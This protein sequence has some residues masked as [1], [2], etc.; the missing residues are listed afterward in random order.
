MIAKFKPT[1]MISEIYNISPTKLDD[2][3]I[4]AVFS[5]LDNT[6]IPWNNPDGTPQLRNWI[7]DL[8]KN[9][10]KLVVISNNKHSRVKRALKSLKLDFISRSCKPMSRG[11]KAALKKY[12]LDRNQVIMVGDQLITDVWASN[13]SKVRSVLVKP[14]IES[15]AWNTKPNRMMETVLWKL[16]KRKYNDLNWQEDIDDRD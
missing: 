10:I 5:D 15:D 2:M 3:G 13:N 4:K 1:W 16:L 6:L 8:E 14:L 9:N 7:K 11:I 12:N